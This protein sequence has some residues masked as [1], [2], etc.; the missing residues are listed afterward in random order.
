MKN[1]LLVC[2]TFLTFV[3][4]IFGASD[5]C[6]GVCDTSKCEES[7]VYCES[8]VFVKDDCD[9]CDVCLRSRG[10]ICG[11]FHARFGKCEVGLVCVSDDSEAF[12]NDE[13][14]DS[15][16]EDVI[17]VCQGW[18]KFFYLQSIDSNERFYDSASAIVDINFETS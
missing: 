16:E 18:Y 11:G 13:G 3:N 4:I 14:S 17:G 10:N 5:S 2:A 7:T 12:M 9:C 15:E 8:G 1:L 6:P